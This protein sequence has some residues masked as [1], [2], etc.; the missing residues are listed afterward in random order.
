[1]RGRHF[2]GPFRGISGETERARIFLTTADNIE[3]MRMIE[4]V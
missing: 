1:V 3:T 4:D 2:E